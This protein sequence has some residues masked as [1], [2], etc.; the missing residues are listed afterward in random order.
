MDWFLYDNGLCHERVKMDGNLATKWVRN[1]SKFRFQYLANSN[2]CPVK[3]NIWKYFWLK[4][5]NNKP[6]AVSG[7]RNLILIAQVS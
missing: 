3:E 6:V 1:V 7:K 2:C 5:T 4:K